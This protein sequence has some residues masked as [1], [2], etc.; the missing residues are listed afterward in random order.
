LPPAGL[1]LPLPSR[2]GA[3]QAFTPARRHVARHLQCCAIGATRLRRGNELEMEHNTMNRYL[4]LRLAS[5][6]TGILL[7]PLGGLADSAWENHERIRGAAADQAIALASALVPGD[8]AVQVTATRL[9]SRLRLPACSNELETF[10]TA[11]QA[12]IPSSVGVR[13]AGTTPWS[14]HVPVKIE[15]IASVV[16]LTTPGERGAPIRPEQLSLEP[17]DIAGMVRGYLT[18]IAAT[19]GMVLKRQALPGTVLDP[20]L[21]EPELIVRRGQQ[22]KLQAGGGAI[23]VS[24]QGE[25]LADAARGDRVRVRN[26]SS[27]IVVEGVVADSGQVVVNR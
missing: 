2:R 6:A 15:V 14:I 17:R 24:I 5:L 3:G 7:W 22:V 4:K 18:E 19:E 16:V 25:A 12:G 1:S 21:L 23:A 26:P 10:G 27:N 13:C 11:G 8:A 9:D 20:T